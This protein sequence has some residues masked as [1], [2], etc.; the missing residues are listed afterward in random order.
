VG[1]S[2]VGE[3]TFAYDD[4]CLNVVDQAY[5]VLFSKPRQ[6]CKVSGVRDFSAKD[7]GL[8]ACLPIDD[9]Y[10]FPR[11]ELRPEVADPGKWFSEDRLGYATNIFNPRY[12]AQICEAAELAPVRECFHPI[13]GLECLNHDSVVYGAP[14]AFWTSRFASI[15]DPNGV[16]ARSAV[17]GFPPVYMKPDQVREALDII[18]F[19]EWKLP[20]VPTAAAQSR[21]GDNASN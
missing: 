6:S 3:D 17:F 19:D 16:A 5:G 10:D 2:G 11:L 12:F 18:L 21:T 9:T 20:R 7:D 4:C 8:R 13:Y 15:A 14:V 1:V